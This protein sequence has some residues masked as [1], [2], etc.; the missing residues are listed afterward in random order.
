MEEDGNFREI[1][2]L[3]EKFTNAHGISGFEHDIREL[4]KKELE[5]YVDTIRKDCMGKMEKALL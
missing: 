4:L 1:K 2:S 5:P 3:L